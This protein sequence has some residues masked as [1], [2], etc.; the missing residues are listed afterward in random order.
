M[1]VLALVAVGVI[2]S[3]SA[4]AQHVHVRS[5]SHAGGP[6]AYGR[7]G[8]LKPGETTRVV[9]RKSRHVHVPSGSTAGGPRRL[10][11]P[12]E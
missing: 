2:L 5:G 7:H 11:R 9:R 1:K 12:G 6:V 3:T 4:L 8:E 10:G